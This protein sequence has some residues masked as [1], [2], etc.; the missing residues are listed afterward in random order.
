MVPAVPLCHVVISGEESQSKGMAS[1]S[2]PRVPFADLPSWGLRMVWVSAPVRRWS[3]GPSLSS[4][5][6][7]AAPAAC[8]APT[9]E[10]AVVVE[11]RGLN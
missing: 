6:S 8:E 10:R 2:R 9:L 11:R 3:E 4:V 7:R 1:S 5:G